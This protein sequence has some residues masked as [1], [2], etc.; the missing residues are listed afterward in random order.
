M[1]YSSSSARFL[2]FCLS[3]L[4]TISSI[5]RGAQSASELIAKGDSFDARL[6][7]ADALDAYLTA[8]KLTPDDPDLLI[9]IAKQYGESMV[10]LADKDDQL[11]AGRRAL[12]YAKRA[13]S[14]APDRLLRKTFR[15][16]RSP[17]VRQPKL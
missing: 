11:A 14:L 10:D 4:F 13:L 2:T 7:T 5:S 17:S 15:P 12:D 9:K 16:M 3:L 6:K 1:K 8:E